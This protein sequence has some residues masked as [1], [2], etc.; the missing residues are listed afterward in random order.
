MAI[1]CSI[2][3]PS[4]VVEQRLARLREDLERGRL[5][6]A[7]RLGHREAAERG[8]SQLRRKFTMICC[9]VTAT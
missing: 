8:G 6:R 1:R 7:R 9:D 5:Y 4:P 2:W 3:R